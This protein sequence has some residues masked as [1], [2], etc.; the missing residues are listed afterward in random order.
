M[1]SIVFEFEGYVPDDIVC[2]VII[3]DDISIKVR[4]IIK[5]MKKFGGAGDCL[6]DPKINILRGA[7]LNTKDSDYKLRKIENVN[8]EDCTLNFTMFGRMA[9]FTVVSRGY[10]NNKYM[11]RRFLSEYIRIEEIIGINYEKV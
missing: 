7:T 10:L 5:L 4:E 6:I 1:R 8:V 9:Y 2:E 3:T 11:T